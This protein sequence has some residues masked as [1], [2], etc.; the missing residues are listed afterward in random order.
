METEAIP[1][2]DEMGRIRRVNFILPTR[3]PVKVI[4]NSST[5]DKLTELHLSICAVDQEASYQFGNKFERSTFLGPN[6]RNKNHFLYKIYLDDIMTKRMKT[7]THVP[8]KG[9]SF[10][11]SVFQ[12]KIRT[13]LQINIVKNVSVHHHDRRLFVSHFYFCYF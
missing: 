9:H 10:R 11:S 4:P 5:I 1:S 2:T 13:T 8:R 12:V 6:P 7:R 3:P